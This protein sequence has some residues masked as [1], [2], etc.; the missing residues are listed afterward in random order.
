MHTARR[1]RDDAA[2]VREAWDERAG[3]IAA[4]EGVDRTTAEARAVV[5]LEVVPGAVRGLTV[6]RVRQLVAD[7]ALRVLA[8]AA[9]ALSGCAP[10]ADVRPTFAENVWAHPVWALLLALALGAALA[11]VVRA[12]TE[13]LAPCRR[14]NCPRCNGRGEEE[15][16]GTP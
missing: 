16:R 13:P 4:A 11:Q 10:V 5:V 6:E 8:L 3:I 15:R 1:E 14:G 9:V 12:I 7:G 2:N